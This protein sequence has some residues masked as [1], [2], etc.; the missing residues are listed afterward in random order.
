MR[1]IMRN[2]AGPGA[3]FVP[4]IPKPKCGDDE[5][6]FKVKAAA[7]CGTD[8]SFWKWNEAGKRFSEKYEAH[9]PFVLGHECCGIVEE[10][11]KNVDNVEIGDKIAIE[12]HIY[13][14]E[15]YQ[16]KNGDAHNCQ[17]LKIYGTS[18]DGAFAEYATA[19]S[20]CVYRLSDAVSFEQGAL[21]EPAG[22]AMFGLQEANV[23]PGDTVM[24]YGC[25]PIGQMTIQLALA[26]G[27]KQVIAVDINDYKKELAEKLGAIGVNS[28]KENLS[29]IVD[30][31]CHER[32]G[33]DVIIE[34]SGAASIYDTM[35][36]Y[37][38]KEGII[39]LLAHPGER[40]SFD[41]MK[42]MHHSGATIK[43][44]FGRRIWKS[45]DELHDLVA[46]G[47]V[48]LSKVITH[49]FPLSE[50][51]KAFNQIM[52]GAGKVLFL[53]EKE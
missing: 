10:K 27:A 7:I 20:K 26:K 43:G 42:T 51:D 19:P 2:E 50:V 17:H 36:D 28:V 44:C 14:G 8:V 31:Y 45:W 38:K 6:L 22:V 13:C 12:T 39:V 24:V 37:L 21:F 47:K 30:K 16:C 18:C 34:V 15:C 52:E 4:N 48:D 32:G 40:V 29:E 9:Y 25:G 23:K 5:V 49:R 41:I 35:A 3:V 46:S 53:P 33:V 11:G 1:A